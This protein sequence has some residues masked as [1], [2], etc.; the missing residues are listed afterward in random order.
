[1][2]TSF[3]SGVVPVMFPGTDCSEKEAAPTA[4]P[5]LVIACQKMAL[6]EI[7]SEADARQLN[8]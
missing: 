6:H 3:L 5:L 4:V 1:M 2:V 7:S 8:E